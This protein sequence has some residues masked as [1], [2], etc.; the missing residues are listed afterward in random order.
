MV[1]ECAYH[2]EVKECSD[3]SIRI[4]IDAEKEFKWLWLSKLTDMTATQDEIEASRSEKDRT[5]RCKK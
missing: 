3:G 2:Y 5:I 1:E 4:E